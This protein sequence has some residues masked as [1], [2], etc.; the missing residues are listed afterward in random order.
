[1]CIVYLLVFCVKKKDK[2]EK[3]V[4]NSSI[5]RDYS[6]YGFGSLI[7]YLEKFSEDIYFI[8]IYLFLCRVFFS[9]K[10]L[11]SSWYMLKIVLDRGR[12]RERK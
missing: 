1:M 12:E 8:M 3:F 9:F 7:V 10:Y 5:I 2:G 4:I 6:I 11:W